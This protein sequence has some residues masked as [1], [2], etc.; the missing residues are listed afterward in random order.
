MNLFVGVEMQIVHNMQKKSQNFKKMH[1]QKAKIKHIDW[2]PERIG[3]NVDRINDHNRGTRKLVCP[4][5]F[6][7]P[8]EPFWTHC[9]VF[10]LR[11]HRSHSV[12]HIWTP[13]TAD[14]EQVRREKTDS[15]EIFDGI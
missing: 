10:Q 5:V 14:F 3:Q 6:S 4:F 12:R 8:S 11:A 15:R 9:E 1:Q 7:P 2:K 13:P